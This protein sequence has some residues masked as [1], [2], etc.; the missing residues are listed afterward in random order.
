MFSQFQ[1]LSVQNRAQ[2]LQNGLIRNSHESFAKFSKFLI[3]TPVCSKY[4]K[5]GAHFEDFQI[6]FDIFESNKR[7]LNFEQT[8]KNLVI[9]RVI[10]D[11]RNLSLL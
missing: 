10:F 6:L 11:M 8:H 7:S 3:F 5:Q 4:Y 9:A 2:F 1:I